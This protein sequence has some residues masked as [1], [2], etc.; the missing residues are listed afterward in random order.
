MGAVHVGV[1]HDDDA[2]VAEVFLL[3]LAATLDPQGQHQVG[4]LL[5]LAQ[6][7]QAGGGDVQ[8]LA[9]QGQDGLGA[10][11]ARLLGR[12]AGAIALDDE[13]LRAVGGVAGAVG[14][15]AGQAQLA[16]RRGAGD[17]LVLA[18]L[19]PLLGAL[20]DEFQ[21]GARGLGRGGE[22]VVEGVAQ[23]GLHQ[24]LGV[25]GGQ[26]LLGLALELGI[27]HEDADQGAGLGDDV[28]GGDDRRALFARQFGVGL[29]AA[30][31]RRAQAGLVRAALGGRHGVAVGGHEAV[32]L[33]EPGRRPGDGP[34]H[35]PGL[36]HCFGARSGRRR[37]R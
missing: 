3:E 13:Q 27:A 17:L 24:P 8:D 26:S 7:V 36:P 33:A 4:E 34:F 29:E 9:T 15:L 32:R 10:A 14:Q 31:Q 21:Q 22:P 25:G 1:G 20:D 37:L 6:L 16:G 30:R 19:Q 23:G 11:V 18:P 35:R 5:V 2:L 12:A 28:L